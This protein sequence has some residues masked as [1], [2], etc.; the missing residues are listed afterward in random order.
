MTASRPDNE[1]IFHAARDIPDPDRRREYV[2]EACG[3]D[4]ARIAH[5]EALLAAAD[6]PDSLLDHP[7]G[8]DPVA[9]TNQPTTENPGALIGPYKL[10]QEIGEGGMGTVWMAQQ[11]EPVKRV[12]AL[13]L[14]KAGMGSRQVVARFEAERQALALMDHA[15]IARVLDAGATQ[16]G[17]PY[18]VMD[19]VKGVPITKY[20]DE[21]R[22]ADRDEQL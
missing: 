21:H 9:T 13:K 16:N 10:L 20:C 18:F 3:G 14:I 22:L 1:A 17:R 11:T 6:A 5:V 15:H 7:A 2:R 4:E 19:L 12:V 8:S